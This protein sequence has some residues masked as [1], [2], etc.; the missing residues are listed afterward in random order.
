M[1]QLEKIIKYLDGEVTGDER[2]AFEKKLAEDVSLQEKLELVKD[3][4]TTLADESLFNFVTKIQEISSSANYKS[5]LDAKEN[6]TDENKKNT[7]ILLKRRFLSA[8]AV[9]LV[10]AISSIFYLNFAG[11][12]NERIYNQFYQKYESSLVTRSGNNETNDLI[13]AIQLY[14]K[15]KY[16]DA[17]ARFSDL[18]Q[19]DNSNT[20]AYFFIGLSYMETKT[21][22]KAITSF[23]AII[24]EQDTAFIEHAEWYMALCYV[25]TN[26]TKQASNLLKHI[27]DSNSFYKIKA[28]DLL[29][30]F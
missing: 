16:K 29:K 28:I 25:R 10:M 8:A 4:N 9:L 2:Q 18:L 30:K 3:L 1:E 5:V 14:D 24:A 6:P 26:Q 12:R 15:G 22:D 7:A 11:P 17:I 21:Y 20:T 13:V 27:S 23:H 19:K